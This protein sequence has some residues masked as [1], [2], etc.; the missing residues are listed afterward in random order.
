MYGALFRFAGGTLAVLGVGLGLGLPGLSAPP[1]QPAV[2]TQSDGSVTAN[3]VA[4]NHDG[5]LLLPANYREWI[6]LSSGVDMVYGPRAAMGHS[7]FDN[8]FVDPAAYRSF[9]EHGVWPD[10][11]MLVLE[12]RG[13]DSNPSINHGG[14]SQGRD[15]MGVEVHLKDSSRFPGGWAFFDGQTNGTGKLL[16]QTAECYSCHRAHAAVDTTFAQFYPTLLPLAKAKGTL[17]PAY[18]KEFPELPGK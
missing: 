7:M 17:S 3:A 10:K 8:V 18:L 1:P 14:H 9:L 6:F 11:T 5:D 4:Y 16:P 15:V 13:A 12:I 2:P